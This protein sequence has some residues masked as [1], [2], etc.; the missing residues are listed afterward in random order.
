[1]YVLRYVMVALLFREIRPGQACHD[2]WAATRHVYGMSGVPCPF[3]RHR[4]KQNHRMNVRNHLPWPLAETGVRLRCRN[5]CAFVMSLR[6][7][8]SRG[9]QTLGSGWGKCRKKTSGVRHW[10]MFENKVASRLPSV[11]HTYNV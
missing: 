4:G 11:T 5:N 7:N 8:M 10:R 2:F 6:A 1:M 3:G 9:K